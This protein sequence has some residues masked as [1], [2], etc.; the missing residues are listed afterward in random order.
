VPKDG[1][2]GDGRRLDGR[3]VAGGIVL[4]LLAIFVIQNTNETGLTFLFWEFS[5][6]LWLTLALTIV[7]SLAIG[8]LLGRRGRKPG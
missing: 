7:I 5:W 4:V 3:V 8:F 2:S 6:P 1:P